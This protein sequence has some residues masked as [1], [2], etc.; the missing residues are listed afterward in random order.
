MEARIKDLQEEVQTYQSKWQKL[1]DERQ[2][3]GQE[4]K[5]REA[6]REFDRLSIEEKNKELERLSSN[7]HKYEADMEMTKER[8][9]F[10]EQQM[11]SRR[12]PCKPGAKKS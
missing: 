11:R 2:I 3:M 10:L 1:E 4:F 9:A 5:Q 8:L 12:K 7:L 6:S